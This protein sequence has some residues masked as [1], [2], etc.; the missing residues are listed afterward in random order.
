[1]RFPLDKYNYYTNEKNGKVIAVSTYGGKT[2]RGVAKCDPSDNF[3]LDFGKK[4][5]A[6]RCNK[7][8]TEKRMKRAWV[9]Y[10]D[11]ID[12]ITNA[13]DH[14]TKMKKYYDDAKN[15]NDL[16]KNELTDFLKSM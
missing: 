14:A 10:Q 5:A 6:L 8:I 11:A 16:A 4:L 7:R 3:S 12:A 15:E 13:L 9:Q 2:V 1:M